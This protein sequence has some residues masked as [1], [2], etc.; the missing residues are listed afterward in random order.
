MTRFFELA[1]NNTNDTVAGITTFSAIMYI[2]VLN[3][4]LISRTG[5]SLNMC[6][7]YLGRQ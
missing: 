6:M 3:Q 5:F 1:K 7:I 2:V 4:T